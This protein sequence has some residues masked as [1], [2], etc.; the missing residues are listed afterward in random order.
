M[1]F[2]LTFST[3]YRVINSSTRLDFR[4]SML[5]MLNWT[6]QS[7]RRVEK[8]VRSDVL[9]SNTS[10]DSKCMRQRAESIRNS[11]DRLPGSQELYSQSMKFT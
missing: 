6:K 10:N 11:N 4:L 2:P 8:Q 7:F 9:G 5:P 1:L 3:I